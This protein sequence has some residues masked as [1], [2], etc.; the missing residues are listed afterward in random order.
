MEHAIESRNLDEPVR[1]LDLG[2]ESEGIWDQVDQVNAGHTARTLVKQGKLRIV[3]M[4]LKKGARIPEH[5]ADGE[6]AFQVL[7]GRIAIDAEG[8]RHELEEGQLMGLTSLIPHDLEAIEDSCVLLT[9]S[10]LR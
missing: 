1:D 2:S 6:S 8:E 9:V 7:S 4:A 3:L 5:T 10:M